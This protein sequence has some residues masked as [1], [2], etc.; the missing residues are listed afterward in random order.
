MHLT[1]S[2]DYA[3]VMEGE[4]ELHLDNG[5]CTVLHQGISPDRSAVKIAELSGDIVIQRGTNHKW[6]KIKDGKAVKILICLIDGGMIYS[7]V[8]ADAHR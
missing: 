1:K 6:L 8:R 2:V 3:I 4:L 5:S 7:C